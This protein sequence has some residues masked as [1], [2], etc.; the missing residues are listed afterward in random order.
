MRLEYL[1]SGEALRKLGLDH[2]SLEKALRPKAGNI[3]V[4]AGIETRP[5]ISCLTLKIYKSSHIP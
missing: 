4:V 1:H 2:K 5:E 3:H